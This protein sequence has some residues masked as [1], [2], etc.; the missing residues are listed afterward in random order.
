MARALSVGV[1]QRVEIASQA[2]N[3]IRLIAR[4][5]LH[6]SPRIR[7]AWMLF[8]ERSCRFANKRC[9]FPSFPINPNGDAVVAPLQSLLNRECSFKIA[10][11]GAIAQPP[12]SS[13]ATAHSSR[14]AS[15]AGSRIASC[16]PPKRRVSPARNTRRTGVDK[17]KNGEK[18]KN[19]K[20]GGKKTG[21]K[22][23][24]IATPCPPHRQQLSLE[25]ADRLG[26]RITSRS[27][28]RQRPSFRKR[29]VSILASR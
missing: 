16:L 1:S 21:K 11:R 6:R 2:A 23:K 17:K 25:Y 20:I 4:E 15:H 19:T 26:I 27:P 13:C 28:S 24:K 9:S 14:L 3:P 29:A 18:K 10:T 8:I 22:Q 5:K 7:V 12:T